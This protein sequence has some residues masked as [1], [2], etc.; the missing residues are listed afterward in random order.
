M[1]FYVSIFLVFIWIFIV[2][3]V[4]ITHFQVIPTLYQI[5]SITIL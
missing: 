1:F 2:N 5:D 4:K 3:I